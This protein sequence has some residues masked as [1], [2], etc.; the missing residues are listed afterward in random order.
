MLKLHHI[1]GLETRGPCPHLEFDF[2]ALLQGAKALARD[3]T[4]VDEAIYPLV[5]GKAYP[6]E[7]LN[8]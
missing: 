4:G 5:L 1:L 7:S 6:V 3:F 2:L 8:Q